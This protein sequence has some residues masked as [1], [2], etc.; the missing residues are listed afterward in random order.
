MVAQ[1]TLRRA[2][3][4]DAGAIAAFVKAAGRAAEVDQGDVADR[5]GHVGFMLAEREGQ[6]VGLLGWQVENLLVRVTDFLISPEVDV[7]ATGKR[8][9][10]TA[11]REGKELQA[12]AVLLFLPAAPS[13]KL[14]AYWD[15][16]GYEA[17][18]SK[19]LPKPWRQAIQE[20]DRDAKGIMV[21]RLRHDIVRRPI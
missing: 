20:G 19:D 12:E 2:R 16:L 8:L 5:F 11:E 3:L 1:I 7:F 13:P 15:Q 17:L 9:I 6:M 4:A 10:E 14:V 21:K 18:T